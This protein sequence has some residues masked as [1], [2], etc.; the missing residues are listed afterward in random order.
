MLLLWPL[1]LGALVERFCLPRCFDLRTARRT[2]SALTSNLQGIEGAAIEQIGRVDAM[3]RT[4]Q[5]V[6]KRDDA[7]G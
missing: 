2:I 5:G 1:S 7:G 6:G 4:A 3:P